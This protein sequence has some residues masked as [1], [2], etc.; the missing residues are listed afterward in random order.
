MTLS[1]ADM[2]KSTFVYVIQSGQFIKIGFSANVEQRVASLQ[3]NLPEKITIIRRWSTPYA[4]EIEQKAH[5]L[6]KHYRVYGEWFSIKPRI[7]T[8][9]IT[10][11]IESRPRTRR[12]K[13]FVNFYMWSCCACT[14]VS[15]NG[16]SNNSPAV[17]CLACG[18]EN[19]MSA[20]ILA[21]LNNVS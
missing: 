4:H 11:L 20:I 6:L 9:L 7:A 17:D 1:A 14:Y 21:K 3:T 12:E 13:S 19:S 15:I 5:R 16:S 2:G 10:K 18:A 8:L